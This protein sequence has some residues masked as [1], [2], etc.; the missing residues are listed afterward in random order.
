[1]SVL[2][3]KPGDTIHTILVRLCHFKSSKALAVEELSALTV[4]Q[5]LDLRRELQAMS[6]GDPE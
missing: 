2:T 1:M 3:S 5:L 6:K 4:M